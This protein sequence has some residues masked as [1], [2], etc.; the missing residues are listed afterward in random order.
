MV[1]VNLLTTEM[2][3]LLLQ[4]CDTVHTLDVPGTTSC[5][6]STAGMGALACF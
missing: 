1:K 2:M 4:L 3:E 6:V 5:M